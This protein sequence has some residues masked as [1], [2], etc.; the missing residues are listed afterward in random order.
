MLTL[1]LLSPVV[2]VIPVTVGA[3]VPTVKPPARVPNCR[4][5]LVTTTSQAPVT[6]PLRLKVQVIWVGLTTE[7]LVAVMVGCPAFVRVTLAPARKPVPT[8][9]V[10][11]TLPVLGAEA[12]AMLV[13]VGAG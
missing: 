7:T 5:V 8:R 3:G 4:S 13:T 12:G 10:M 2:G 1:P 9:L 6:A 11:F